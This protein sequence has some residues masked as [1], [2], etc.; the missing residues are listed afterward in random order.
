MKADVASALRE[1]E[2]AHRRLTEA[3]RDSSRT[4]VLHRQLEVVTDELRKRVGSVFTLDE[5]AAEYRHADR[6]AHEAVAERAAA[7]GWTATLTLVEGAAFRLYARRAA[8]YEP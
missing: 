5:L 3:E 1:W 6:W 4:E 7:P 2:D 8:D